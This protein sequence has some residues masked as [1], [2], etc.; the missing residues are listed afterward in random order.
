M[1]STGG[2]QVWSRMQA[3]E[4]F[5]KSLRM[6]VNPRTQYAGLEKFFCIYMEKE[7]SELAGKG[8]KHYDMDSVVTSLEAN[9][10]TAK[11]VFGS[12]PLFR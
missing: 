11:L 4:F 3:I 10:T 2:W 7:T 12:I 5:I 1:T 8:F 6:I 9:R